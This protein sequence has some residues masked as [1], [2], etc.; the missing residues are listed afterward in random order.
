MNLTDHIS[1]WC[2][3]GEAIHSQNA[4]RLGIINIPSDEVLEDMKYTATHIFD[5]VREFINEPLTASSFF[6]C[7]EL[8]GN[9]PGSSNTSQHV[10]GQAVDM[11][12]TGR[13]VDI[14]KF[15]RDHLEFDQLLWEYGSTVVPAWVHASITSHR[16]NRKQ[17][18]RV[19]VDENKQIHYIP[20]DLHI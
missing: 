4:E 1:K 3:Y 6:R 18:L 11:Y 16:A 17:I 12:S 13:L 15:V 7:A 10:L 8:N 9:T 20:F 19:Y 2:S 5:P 14:F